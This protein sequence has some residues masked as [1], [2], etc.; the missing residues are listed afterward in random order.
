MIGVG[1]VLHGLGSTKD[2][3][4]IQV[5][6]NSLVK[7]NYISICFDATNSIGLSGGKY[8][9][10][11]MEKHYQDLEDILVWLK[12]QDFYKVN[13]IL[14]GSSLGGYAVLRY[15]EEYPD[16]V[17]GVFATAPVI[18]GEMSFE[19]YQKYDVENFKAWEE[20]GWDIRESSSVPGLIK[21]LPWSHMLERLQHNLLIKV[22]NLTMPISIIVGDSDVFCPKEHQKILFDLIPTNKKEFHIIKDA[23][24][25]FR[26][27][28]HLKQL[29]E[30]FD[31]WLKKI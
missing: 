31:S 11:T 19:S 18:S 25:T 23:P 20:T 6:S 4:H 14:S 10:A 12:K 27:E 22:K 28:N 1:V 16:E 15:A 8:E 21:K 7:N 5:I 24:H 17:K 13:L 30:I 9:D 29:E 26:E 3:K 2:K